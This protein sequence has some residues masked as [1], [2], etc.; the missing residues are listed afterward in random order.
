M[1]L[2]S[3]TQAYSSCRA[4]RG[5]GSGPNAR[6]CQTSLPNIREI[7]I[8][9]NPPAPAGTG[10]DGPCQRVRMGRL[11]AHGAGEIADIDAHLQRAGA[12]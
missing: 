9:G 12:R 10:A 11:D 1:P 8:R 2:G 3:T 7:V 5:I 6:S 4:A